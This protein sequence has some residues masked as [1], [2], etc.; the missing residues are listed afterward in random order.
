MLEMRNFVGSDFNYDHRMLIPKKTYQAT[1]KSLISN[2]RR[3][4]L[5]GESSNDHSLNI[6][7]A[8]I[9]WRFKAFEHFFIRRDQES[10]VFK[11]NVSV[12]VQDDT[13]MGAAKMMSETD[14]DF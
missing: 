7:Q 6:N 2:Y 13:S 3:S 12:P 8:N 10:Q 11:A 9:E 4:V 1:K 5:G 14:N